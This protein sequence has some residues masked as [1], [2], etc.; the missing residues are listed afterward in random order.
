MNERKS[1]KKVNQALNN[2]IS[3]LLLIFTP[4]LKFS[5]IKSHYIIFTLR[6]RSDGVY[7]SLKLTGDPVNRMIIT[8]LNTGHTLHL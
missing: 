1:P 5:M 4:P 6:F 8:S 2:S 3:L 7:F